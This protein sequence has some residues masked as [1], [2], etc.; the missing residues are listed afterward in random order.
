MNPTLEYS[1]KKLNI[2]AGRWFA[3]TMRQFDFI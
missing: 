3:S 1:L 2:E